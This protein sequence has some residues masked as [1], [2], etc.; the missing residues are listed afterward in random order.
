[1]RT[2][3]L[4]CLTVG[5]P[6]LV[7]AVPKL[8][9]L[10]AYIE[11]ATDNNY[12]FNPITSILIIEEDNI[13]YD[14][15]H[16]QGLQIAVHRFNPDRT[17]YWIKN[18]S[19]PPKFPYHKPTICTA[20]T[21]TGKTSHLITLPCSKPLPIISSPSPNPPPGAL[22]FALPVP[23]ERLTNYPAVKVGPRCAR[24]GNL[25]SREDNYGEDCLALHVFTPKVR[26]EVKGRGKGLP[27]VV[28][29]H[30]GAL[31]F[32]GRDDLGASQSGTFATRNGGVVVLPQ[33]RMGFLGTFEETTT[34]NR[35][36]LP[37]NQFVHDQILALKWVQKNIAHFGGDPHRVLISGQ[38]SG[39]W[40]VRHLI[41]SPLAKGPFHRAILRSDSLN[42]PLRPETSTMIGKSYMQMAG[43]ADLDCMRNAPL[44]TLL[45]AQSDFQNVTGLSWFYASVDNTTIPDLLHNL[46]ATGKYNK[47]PM[48]C[49]ATNNEAGESLTIPSPLPPT[50][51][52]A[53]LQAFYPPLTQNITETLLTTLYNATANQ[54]DWSLPTARFGTA[55]TVA[56]PVRYTAL[57]AAHSVPVRVG[58]F[59]AGIRSL[60]NRPGLCD[61]G[62]V[63][64]SDDNPI[65]SG[66]T[67]YDVPWSAYNFTAVPEEVLEVS[68]RWGDIVSAFARS[69][70]GEVGSERVGG[71]VWPK[72]GEGKRDGLVLGP[73]KEWG[74]VKGVFEDQPCDLFDDIKLCPFFT[75]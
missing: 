58:T 74:V 11:V 29:F 18:T 25:N 57:L 40:A 47:V 36:T 59:A 68:R 67:Q 66:W 19:S 21:T 9:G 72:I 24:L 34:Y 53:F 49:T 7:S 26:K 30:G 3:T 44:E 64:H 8:P 10:P 75:A 39:A 42:P 51:A 71:Y 62:W 5:V 2:G 38:S 54:S 37:G 48:I 4:L 13:T 41:S 46:L 14:P 61:G 43:C 32:G 70:D 22:R 52:I 33:F 56:C 27:V 31:N 15:A 73:G 55:G 65:A 50:S 6:V 20:Y 12:G 16:P 69:S 17:Q 1:M 63:C 45:K 23:K 28:N 60:W 35:S